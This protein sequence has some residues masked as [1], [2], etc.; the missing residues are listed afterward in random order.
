MTA[1]ILMYSTFLSPKEGITG[2]A[3]GLSLIHI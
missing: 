1:G 2:Y 3:F